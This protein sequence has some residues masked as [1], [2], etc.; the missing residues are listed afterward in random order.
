M[1]LEVQNKLITTKELMIPKRYADMLGAKLVFTNGCFDILHIGH[2]RMFEECSYLNGGNNIV[3]V[4]VNSDKSI[5]KIKGKDRPFNKQNIRTEM[6]SGIQY[7]N[8]ITSFDDTSILPLLEVMKPDVLVK[9]GTTEEIEGKD[10]VES[11]GGI[12]HKTKSFGDIST[13]KILD[14]GR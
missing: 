13:T 12:V 4:A 8:Y 7:I 1:M 14:N 5:K 9:G 10:Y 6:L 11:Y 3:V 2:M